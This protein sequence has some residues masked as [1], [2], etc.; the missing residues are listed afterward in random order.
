MVGMT[1]LEVMLYSPPASS[2]VYQLGVTITDTDVRRLETEQ[3]N[4][5]TACSTG[6]GRSSRDA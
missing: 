2:D 4:F 5:E 3:E 6:N 1:L